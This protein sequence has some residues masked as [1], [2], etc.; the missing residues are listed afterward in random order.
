MSAVWAM[1]AA[2]G[3]RAIISVLGVDRR[4]LIFGGAALIGAALWLW[5]AALRADAAALR[6][7]R[8]ALTRELAAVR[9][10]SA[11]RARAIDV[12]DGA[13]RADMRRAEFLKNAIREARYADDAQSG[14]VAPVLERALERLRRRAGAAKSGD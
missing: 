11:A 6:V 3:Q 2:F 8:G 4:L 13:L 10:Q 14:A 12:L 5:I 7:E 9:A 1:L